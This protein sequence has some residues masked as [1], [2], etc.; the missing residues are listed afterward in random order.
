MTKY[1]ITIL[2]F[3]ALLAGVLLYIGDD[4]T[5]LLT[6]SAEKGPLAFAPLELTWQIV[7][8]LGTVMTL[9]LIGLWSIFLWLW[10][11]PRRVKS[12]VGLRRRNQALDAME[13]ALI[14]G[15][16][17]D[18][19]VAR[20]KSEKARQLV[21]STDLGR[22][23][24]A[25]AAEACGDSEEAMA[26]YTAMLDSDKTRVTGQRGLA[27]NML[28]TGDIPG[29]I[30][31]SQRAYRDNKNARWA[32]DT[33]FKA[34]VADHRWMDALETLN[35]GE[36][37]KH[38]DGEDARRRRAV[39]LTAEADRLHDDLRNGAALET[40]AKALTEAPSFAPAVAL[41][42]KLW[43]LD[44]QAKK[45]A[46]VIEKAWSQAPHPALSLAYLD[47]FEGESD[48]TRA[49]KVAGLIAKNPTHRES[50]LLGVEND[51][52]TGDAV[53]AWSA[54]A[55]LVKV[56]NPTA[57]LCLLAAQAEQRLNNDADARL[58]TERA[59]TAPREPNW[60][61]L[62]P[63]GEGFDYSAQDWRRL[64]FSY[65]DTGELIHP[66]A[67]RQAEGRRPGPNNAP[68]TKLIIEQ[69]KA[70]ETSPV[71]LP[72]QPDDP[73]IPP[74]GDDL[75]GRLDSLLDKD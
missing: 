51:L 33:L 54:L 68:D 58:W 67:E 45:A 47:L 6:S 24:S 55:P 60:S 34:Q 70:P 30:E 15:A 38:I 69:K 63:S 52:R 9:G 22:I 4:V 12:G 64:V 44:G 59:A 19:K 71:E 39:V 62:D 21:G 13:E 42:A 40:V 17:G 48:K 2:V 74:T 36:G 20:K 56:E 57:R 23:I 16:E 7:I 18:M 41:A 65:G 75:A 35:T 73:G 28:V 1:I 50:V 49:R 46:S 66:R 29:A 72:H 37:R 25:Q 14:A 10:R 5:L 8:L 31:Q 61:D 3:I 26:Q 53:S 11:L 27:Q 32:F 43:R